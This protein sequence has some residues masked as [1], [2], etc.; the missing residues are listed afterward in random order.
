MREAYL[1]GRYEPQE[2]AI[3]R[4]LV[5]P[6]M[7]FADVGANWGYFTLVAAHLAGPSGRV[8]SVEADARAVAAIRAN[9]AANRLTTVRVFD[10]AATDVPRDL[11]F[12]RYEPVRASASG[13][14]GLA[15]TASAPDGRRPRVVVRGRPL[16]DVFD[17]AGVPHVDVLKMDIEGGEAAA[18]R[19][20]ERYLSSGRIDFIVLELHPAALD[21]L[22]TSAA[23][24]CDH[25]SAAGYEGWR[26]HHSPTTHY[27][28]ALPAVDITTLLSPLRAG[29][30]LG[31]W[32]HV[33]WRRRGL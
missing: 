13:N 9:V 29:S 4:D 30:D 28:A 5:R 23:A 1:T 3:I 26:I 27:R 17:E 7:T 14:F 31:V 21:R 22:G 16:D 20:L 33:L 24:V 2:T 8:I 19:G 15:E 18:L 6:G 25:L 11:S 32:P 12:E 10:I